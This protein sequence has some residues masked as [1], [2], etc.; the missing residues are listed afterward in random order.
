MIFNYIEIVTLKGKI[1]YVAFINLDL[2]KLETDY[3]RIVVLYAS[4]EHKW[5]RSAMPNMLFKCCETG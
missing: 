3:L 2:P 4:V 1:L 5:V